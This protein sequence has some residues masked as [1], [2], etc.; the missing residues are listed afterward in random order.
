MGRN[1]QISPLGNIV[2]IGT[3]KIAPGITRPN[4][5]EIVHVGIATGLA[6]NGTP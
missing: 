1:D 5:Q 2:S 3:G 6:L 4:Q